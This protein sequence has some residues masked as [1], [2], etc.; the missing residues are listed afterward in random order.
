[1]KRSK[2]STTVAAK[3][4][5]EERQLLEAAARLEEITIS[6]FLGRAAVSSA[7]RRLEQDLESRGRLS[8][9]HAPA[10]PAA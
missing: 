9:E 3:V 4:T 2:R 5:A 10:L 6:E 7:H 8:R 1:M